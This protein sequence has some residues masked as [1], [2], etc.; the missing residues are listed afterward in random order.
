MYRF[1]CNMGDPLWCFWC[2]KF[3]QEKVWFF[4]FVLFQAVIR[5]GKTNISY[6]S[7]FTFCTS[8]G[9]KV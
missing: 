5:V 9:R 4:V 1:F 3:E 2:Q 6:S 8:L 7:S